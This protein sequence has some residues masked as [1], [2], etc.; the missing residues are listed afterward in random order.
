MLEVSGIRKSFGGFRALDWKGE[1]SVTFGAGQIWAIA[2][3]NGAGKSTLSHI[4]A[5][6]FRRD[7]GE[8]RLNGDHY[9]PRNIREAWNSGTAM[10]LQEPGLVSSL[11]VA[12][13]LFLGR[14]KHY[15]TAFLQDPRRRRELA[16]E[17]LSDLCS[18]VDPDTVARALSLE[19][20]KLVELARAL[21]LKP[22]VLIIDETSA[23]LSGPNVET[24]YR[25]MREERDRGAV[26]LFIS[27]RFEEMFEHSDHILVLKDGGLVATLKSSETTNE[28]L[29]GLM[30]GREVSLARQHRTSRRPETLLEAKGL[31]VPGRFADVSFRVHAGEIVGIGGLAGAGQED[32]LRA[33]FGDHSRV[34][35]TVALRGKEVRIDS[36]RDAIAQGLAFAPRNRDRDGL[37]L[38]HSVRENVA[39]PLLGRLNRYGLV[40]A[41]KEQRLV[42][43]LVKELRIKCQ[44]TT[45]ACG[46]L[47]GGNRQKVVLARW[48]GTGASVLLLDNPTRGIDVGSK[49]EIYSLMGK[50]AKQGI[51]IVMVSDEMPELLGMSDRILIL[52]RGRV[53]AQLENVESL[54]EHDLIRHMI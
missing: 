54:S 41:N 51:G 42:D 13:N 9:A 27:H 36:P 5:G 19:D 18:H 38:N 34:E 1:A 37:V 24:L 29:S 21:S 30:V 32:V 39:L 52:R 16:R 23:A 25:K 33:L 12:E 7:A 6:I 22:S 49:A 11:T 53:S 10:V 45:D 14:E 8:V 44:R 31:G 15:T 50:L 20:Q 2:G 43:D 40:D 35:G 28:E 47:S 26:V 48:I 17:V 3:E 46:S 4:L